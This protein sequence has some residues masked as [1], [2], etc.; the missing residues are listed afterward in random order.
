MEAELTALAVSGATTLVGLM[1]SETWTQ[2]RDRVA[3]FFARGGDQGSAVEELGRSQ[4]ELLA[5]RAAQDELAGADIE[6]EW[7][8]R[9]RRIL[10]DDPQAA[11]ELRCLLAELGPSVDDNHGASVHNSIS[12]GVQN[13]P[14]VQGQSFSGLT[15]G[16]PGR[17]TPE[18]GA[19]GQ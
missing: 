19:S 1:V 15:F 18:Q 14:V 2:A 6:A 3:R 5:A 4:Q 12:G 8:T 10:Q 11:E 9:L 16:V 17:V 13:G 7:R